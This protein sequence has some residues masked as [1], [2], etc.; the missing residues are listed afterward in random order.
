MATIKDNIAMKGMSGKLGDTR[1]P[2][3][4]RENYCFKNSYKNSK[5]D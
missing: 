3:K 2:T 4:R 5:N 1:L